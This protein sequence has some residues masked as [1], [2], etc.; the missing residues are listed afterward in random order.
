MKYWLLRKLYKF[1]Y[2]YGQLNPD[3]RALYGYCRRFPEPKDVPD[4]QLLHYIKKLFI[5]IEES[6]EGEE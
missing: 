3:E 1:F 5:E 6:I 4:K 2:W